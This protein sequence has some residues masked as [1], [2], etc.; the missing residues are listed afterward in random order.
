MAGQPESGQVEWELDERY[1]QLV[2]LA[3]DGILVHHNGRI[4]LANASAVRLAGATQR[5]ELVGLPIDAFL[6][7]PY[8]KAVQA[9]LT[10]S[11]RP[12]E[13]AAPMRDTFRRLDGSEVAVEVRTVA[14]M[15]Q[16][17]PAAHVIIRDIS[18]RLAAEQEAHEVEQ[19]LY[20]AQR[21]EA[22][23]ALAGGVAH[24]V[25]NMM[26][27]VLGYGAFLLEDPRLPAECL[28]DVRE[29]TKAGGRAAAV[30][31]Q[32]LNFARRTES[33]RRSVDLGALVRDIE[34]VLHRLLGKERR[35]VVVSETSPRVFIDPGQLEQVLVNFGL[36]ARDAMPAGG[37]L[38][39]T[40][41]T[42]TLLHA[43]AAADGSTIP[44]ESY[45]TLVMRDTGTGMDAVTREHIFEPFFTTKPV[46]EGTGLG[47]AAALGIVQ[48]NGGYITVATAPGQGAAFT[49]YLPVLP[50]VDMVDTAEP[51]EVGEPPRVGEAPTHIG[52]TVLIV[53]DEPAVRA[54]ATRILERGGF[55]V[56]QAASGP[57]ALKLVDRHGPPD[58]VLTD[59]S[60]PG[61]GGAELVRRL[62]ERW[63]ALGMLFMSGVSV[64]ELVRHGEIVANVE[65]VLK[66]FTPVGLLERVARALAGRRRPGP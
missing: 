24:E 32:L 55:R 27:V 16:D 15:D 57:D 60:M 41:S 63:P 26:A 37:T 66:P 21:M 1:Q 2:E 46:G 59:L 7:P 48:Q 4:V 36:N 38:T 25:N 42:S 35:L 12:A 11:D 50:I 62:K 65:I 23:G 31:R 18:E 44:P 10:A 43:V 49:I 39:L 54:I 20:R 19:R 17:H 9:Q 34:P 47:L 58:L 8:L 56:F 52:A 14:F 3:P 53:D 40:T 33:R 64:E 28:A 61:F 45:A 22:V 13:P 6:D 30:T 5:S 29:I 51:E